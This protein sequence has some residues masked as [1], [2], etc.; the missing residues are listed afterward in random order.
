MA[1]KKIIEKVPVTDLSGHLALFLA[2][3][4]G[5]GYSPV[6]PGTAGSLLAVLIYLLLSLLAVPLLIYIAIC[7]L[8]TVVGCFVAERAGRHFGVVDAQQIVI[9]E[10]AGLLISMTATD[11]SFRSLIL[12]FTLFRIFDIFKPWPASYFDSTAQGGFGVV[13]D[14][15][16]AGVYTLICLQTLLYF[17]IL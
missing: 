5:C 17:K 2:T 14:D 1:E 13:M 9:D 12:G 6:A 11:L 8:V 15:V 7:L 3:G 16:A 10:V 4:L